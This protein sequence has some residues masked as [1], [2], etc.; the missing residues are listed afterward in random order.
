MV[1]CNELE[2]REARIAHGEKERVMKEI[3]EDFLEI[4]QKRC[5][6]TADKIHKAY[7]VPLHELTE[8]MPSFLKFED[9]VLKL[10]SEFCLKYWKQGRSVSAKKRIAELEAIG[11]SPRGEFEGQSITGGVAF[12]PKIR[13]NSNLPCSRSRGKAVAINLKSL[14]EGEHDDDKIRAVDEPMQSKSKYVGI[15]TFIELNFTLLFQNKLC[16]DSKKREDG[17]RKGK[18]KSEDGSR[19]K[20]KKKGLGHRI[21]YFV[22]TLLS[23]L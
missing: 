22:T 7:G 6:I 9:Q 5:Q 18:N 17:R 14:M 12:R 1:R 21:G 11:I 19:F 10:V 20:K 3:R 13:H 8:R 2:W 4:D 16:S 15:E 23:R